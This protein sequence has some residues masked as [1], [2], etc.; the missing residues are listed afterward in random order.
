MVSISGFQPEDR[1][2]IPRIGIQYST[3]AV[4]LAFNQEIRVRS[5]VLE[6]PIVQWLERTAVNR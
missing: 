3:M 1:G 2:S 5:P 4:R 6:A